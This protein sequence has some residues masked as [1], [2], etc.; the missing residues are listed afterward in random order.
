M[1]KLFQY[2]FC[3][4]GAVDKII[5]AFRRTDW[6]IHSLENHSPFVEGP[7]LRDAT[8][9]GPTLRLGGYISALTSLAN[10]VVNAGKSLRN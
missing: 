2:R 1:L 8:F 5:S 3:K 4:T 6:P 9:R 7:T 10:P